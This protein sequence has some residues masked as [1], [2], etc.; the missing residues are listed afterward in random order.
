MHKAAFYYFLL[1]GIFF[2]DLAAF[3]LCD[4][5]WLY[6]IIC[7]YYAQAVYT[8]SWRLL[9]MPGFLV[10]LESFMY[11]NCFG[12]D[13]TCMIPLTSMF[14]YLKKYIHDGILLVIIG[15]FLS[16]LLHLL[17]VY[18]GVFGRQLRC[19]MP[20]K[21]I[22]IHGILIIIVCYLLRGNQGNRL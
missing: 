17:I 7:L 3:K 8:P 6:G 5:Q 18:H 21:S 16:F 11:S 14:Y 15:T 20:L 13:L 22:V 10:L 9:I 1:G 4:S 12:V 2:L 19:L